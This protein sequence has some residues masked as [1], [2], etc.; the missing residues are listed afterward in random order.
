[1]SQEAQDFVDNIL[2]LFKFNCRREPFLFFDE[3][4]HKKLS[5]HSAGGKT[6]KKLL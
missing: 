4:A 5:E 1:M 2:E 6:T 3:G